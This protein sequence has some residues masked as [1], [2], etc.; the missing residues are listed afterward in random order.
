MPKAKVIV[1]REI[2]REQAKVDNSRKVSANCK[3]L[4]RFHGGL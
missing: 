2:S 3:V 4:L 1:L